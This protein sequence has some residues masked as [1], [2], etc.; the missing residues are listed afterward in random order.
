M[1]KLCLCAGAFGASDVEYDYRGWRR[2][3]QSQNGAVAADHGRCSVIGDA[4][5]SLGHSNPPPPP[6]P[7]PTTLIFLLLTP[8]TPLIRWSSLFLCLQTIALIYDQISSCGTAA[9]HTFPSY[10]QAGKQEIYKATAGQALLVRILYNSWA[11]LGLYNHTIWTS[12]WISVHI[13]WSKSKCPLRMIPLLVD[14]C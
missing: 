5:L 6:P 11:K 8:L 1:V 4:H 14:D 2:Q 12:S 7:H 13:F 10:V 3:I 9:N